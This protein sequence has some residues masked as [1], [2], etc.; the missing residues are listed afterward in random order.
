ME[1]YLSESWWGQAKWDPKAKGRPL[2]FS[3][4]RVFDECCV[5]WVLGA[6]FTCP[7]PKSSTHPMS[8]SFSVWALHKNERAWHI[9]MLLQGWGTPQKTANIIENYYPV[10]PKANWT[11]WLS[12]SISHQAGNRSYH[13]VMNN[14]LC[15]LKRQI[16]Y[17]CGSSNF[18]PMGVDS[19]KTGACCKH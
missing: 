3:L 10:Y 16:K 9:S 15:V 19:N 11:N 17:I 8:I 1:L 12:R 2:Q 4:F 14:E 6:R 7:W 5:G 18:T 13:S